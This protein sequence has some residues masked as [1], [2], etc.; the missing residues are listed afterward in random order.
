MKQGDIIKINFNPQSGHQQA[1]YRPAVVISNS[2]FNQKTNLT[3]ACPIT[4]TKRG[5]P[6]HVELDGRTQ[7]TGVIMCE[8]IKSLD[9]NAREHRFVEKLPTDLLQKVIDIV[10][11][12][13]ETE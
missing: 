7:T 9:L 11:A 5:F 4:N 3:I 2:V 8:H 12:E 10:F 6:L 13:V 1:G